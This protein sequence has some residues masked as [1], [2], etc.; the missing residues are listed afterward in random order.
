LQAKYGE[1]AVKIY[2]E[3]FDWQNAPIDPKVVYSSRG[4]K[5][6]GEWDFAIFYLSECGQKPYYYSLFSLKVCHL[7]WCDWLEGGMTFDGIYQRDLHLMAMQEKLRLAEEKLQ[8]QEVLSQV[9]QQ[10]LEH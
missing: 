5:A 4:G 10:K 2:G 6:H 7:R 9:Q 3:G 1:E 8:R